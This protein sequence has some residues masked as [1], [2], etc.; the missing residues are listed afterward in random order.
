MNEFSYKTNTVF[1]EKI[2]F[3]LKIFTF[4]CFNV[5]TNYKMCDVII[6]LIAHQKSHSQFL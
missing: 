3:F 5:S 6:D 2:I 4:F 1:E